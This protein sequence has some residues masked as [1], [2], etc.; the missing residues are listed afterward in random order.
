M[1]L[2]H[3]AVIGFGEAGSH[4]AAGPREA[5]L[6]LVISAYDIRFPVEPELCR[7]TEAIAVTPIGPVDATIVEADLVL[8][9][10]VAKQSVTVAEIS[11]RGMRDGQFYVDCNSASPQ[12]KE[13]VAAVFTGTN[14]KVVDSG[15][16]S[17]LPGNRH[18]VPMTFSG[19]DAIEA[20]DLL[21]ALGCVVDTMDGA[22]GAASALKM[23]RSVTMKGI[24]AVL[25]EFVQ[26]A[27]HYGVTEAVLASM[28]D[29]YPG[30]DWVA[31]APR[32]ISRASE[33]AAR[34]ASE[35]REVSETL[36]AVGVEP[37]MSEA[38]SRRIAEVAD[39][40][41]GNDGKAFGSLDEVIAAMSVADQGNRER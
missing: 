2:N 23:M 34:R 24:D 28:S 27:R 19:P 15:V 30:V 11:A 29:S 20:A 4:F 7:K 14:V 39:L 9:F 26:G 36:R 22:V 37:L 21:N 38:A 40:L 16:M 3:V 35:M 12:M 13:Q 10:V 33:H 25:L 8:S 18:T 41:E 5:N 1:A 31:R 17:A 6:D 32:S